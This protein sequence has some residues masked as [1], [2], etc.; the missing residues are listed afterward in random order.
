MTEYY[1]L[2]PLMYDTTNGST[3]V[4]ISEVGYTVSYEAF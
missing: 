2:E 3:T 4:N 1:S